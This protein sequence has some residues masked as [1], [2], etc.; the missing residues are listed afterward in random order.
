MNTYDKLG[1]YSPSEL[2]TP[3]SSF[4]V[5]D[6]TD[7]S[8]TLLWSS[9]VDGLD[10]NVVI[11]Q[12]NGSRWVNIKTIAIDRVSDTVDE[13]ES[14]TEYRFRVCLLV[15]NKLY[16]SKPISQPTDV[17]E[18]IVPCQPTGLTATTVSATTVTLQWI[19]RCQNCDG[20]CTGEYTILSYEAE[21]WESLA[22]VDALEEETTLTELTPNTTYTI[23][24]EY[25]GDDSNTIEFTTPSEPVGDFT[26]TNLYGSYDDID[27][28]F[29]IG[30]TR[31]NG[32]DFGSFTLTVLPGAGTI[33]DIAWWDESTDFDASALEAGEYIFIVT[34]IA[35]DTT[36]YNSDPLYLTKS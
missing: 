4:E 36:E 32:E 33:T 31:N 12:W 15:D 2:P 11:Q 13:L 8:I 22:T 24:I 18:V 1:Q 25:N 29:S 14:N 10:G 28:A 27:D 34:Y 6:V 20:G 5:I 21:M 19:K 26:P 9:V 30:W 7:N 3:P 17:G 35:T 23:K 16:P